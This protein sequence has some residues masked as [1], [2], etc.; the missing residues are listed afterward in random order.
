[1]DA[2]RTRISMIIAYSSSRIARYHYSPETPYC[3]ADMWELVKC[4]ERII[5]IEFNL[6][7]STPVFNLIPQERISV[8]SERSTHSHLREMN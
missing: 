8:Y 1:M 2:R 5:F 4:G 3:R 7:A 6:N